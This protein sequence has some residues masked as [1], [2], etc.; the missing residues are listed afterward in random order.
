MRPPEDAA[1]ILSC[2]PGPVTLYPS[3]KKWFGVFLGCAAFAAGSLL[4]LMPM[5]NLAGPIVLLSSN[6]L[7]WGGLVFFGSGMVITVGVMLPGASSL[8]LDREGF[9]IIKFFRNHSILWKNAT[10]FKI[11]SNDM[12]P[13]VKMVVFDNSDAKKRAMARL[14]VALSGRN[15]Y[16]PD[17]YGFSAEAL[18]DLMT[19]WRERAAKLR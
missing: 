14:N 8:K 18:A 15:A 9:E 6:V 11:W 19:Q 10:G 3:R 2:F 16:L 17:T 13:K 7:G 4:I 1:K 5:S 12:A